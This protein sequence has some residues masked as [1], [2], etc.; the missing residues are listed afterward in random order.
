MIGIGR[1][2]GGRGW[3]RRDGDGDGVGVGQWTCFPRAG[4]DKIFEFMVGIN[5]K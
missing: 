4:R 5:V 2:G 1:G 3:R